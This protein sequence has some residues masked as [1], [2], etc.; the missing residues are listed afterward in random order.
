MSSASFFEQNTSPLEVEGPS[1]PTQCVSVLNSYGLQQ[2]KLLMEILVASVMANEPGRKVGETWEHFIHRRLQRFPSS[3]VTT[4]SISRVK[5]KKKD[6]RRKK[7]PTKRELAARAKKDAEKYGDPGKAVLDRNCVRTISL[8]RHIDCLDPGVDPSDVGSGQV[9]SVDE[10]YVEWTDEFGEG[11]ILDF[12]QGQGFNVSSDHFL[13]SLHDECERISLPRQL[14]D[15]IE[16]EV[17]G[18]KKRVRCNC[19]DYNFHYICFHQVT[20]ELLQFCKL[21]NENCSKSTEN[22]TVIRSRVLEYLKK[23]YLDVAVKS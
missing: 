11:D 9:G 5:K 19:E 23:M 16:V 21:P 6:I 13:Q 20:F 17:D 2:K 7:P 4:R 15:W 14:G 18:V 1:T 22:W 10:D 8:L 12:L 3:A